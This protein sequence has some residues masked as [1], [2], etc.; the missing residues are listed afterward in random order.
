LVL[1]EQIIGESLKKNIELERM[2]VVTVGDENEGIVSFLKAFLVKDE[3]ERND[4]LQNEIRCKGEHC[5]L[6]SSQK[7]ALLP[8][9]VLQQEDC[10]LD[11]ELG[12]QL[13]Y[14]GSAF[15]VKDFRGKGINNQLLFYA[16]YEILNK[17]SH[18]PP[19]IS[20]LYGQVQSNLSNFSMIKIFIQVMA[21]LRNQNPEAVSGILKRYFSIKPEITFNPV[22]GNLTIEFPESNHGAGNVFTL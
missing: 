11:F 16:L 18:L 21:K 4:L 2:F 13:V 7:M 19:S 12:D 6:L 3:N 17:D 9:Q 15:T 20:F 8:K 1:P 10:N 5:K 22:G 14:Y